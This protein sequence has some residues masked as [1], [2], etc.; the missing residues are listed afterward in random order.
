[1]NKQ[2]SL[3]LPQKLLN[4]AEKY[5][6]DHGFD[7]LQ[8]FIREIVRKKIYEEDEVDI[9]IELLELMRDK[10]FMDSYIKSKEQIKEREFVDWNEL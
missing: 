2:I 6:E 9:L 5:A 10:E 8:E 7:N 4:E 3:R 1:M